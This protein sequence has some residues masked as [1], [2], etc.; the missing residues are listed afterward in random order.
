MVFFINGS[1]KSVLYFLFFSMRYFTCIY[2]KLQTNLLQSDAL[3]VA[4]LEVGFQ[5]AHLGDDLGR[6]TTVDKLE[7]VDGDISV[8]IGLYIDHQL[9]LGGAGGEG[10]G[11][12]V[13]H[14]GG[15]GGGRQFP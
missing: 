9:E 3:A 10:D 5:L 2:Q 11:G 6:H 4:A 13:P 8:H 7:V 15:G 12:I 1:E 14:I